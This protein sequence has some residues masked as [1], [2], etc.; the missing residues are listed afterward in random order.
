MVPKGAVDI[1]SFATTQLALLDLELQSELSET[2]SLIAT[3]SPTSLQRAGLA[4]TNL[5]LNSQRTGLGGKTVVELGPDSATS[6]AD[7][8]LPEHGIRTG[9]IVVVS[10][11]PAGSAKKR[12]VKELESKGSRGVVTRVSRNGV[13]VALDKDEDEGVVGMKRVWVVKLAN[14]VTYKR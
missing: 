12:E 4:I 13:W 2:S 8:E 10:E 7:G 11:Q 14:D 1:S 9:D 3:I 5:V 6:N